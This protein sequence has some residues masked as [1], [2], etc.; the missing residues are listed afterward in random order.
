MTMTS[1][2]RVGLVALGL[3]IASALLLKMHN[4]A[5]A[6]SF[7][8]PA[9]PWWALPRVWIS[10]SVLVPAVVP[11][12]I[13]IP[14]SVTCAALAMVVAL[15]ISV[16]SNW[17]GMVPHMKLVPTRTVVWVFVVDILEFMGATVILASAATWGM[18]LW[19]SNISLQADR[20]R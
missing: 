1:P 16:W 19:S 17:A 4:E 11:A 7:E 15:A 14:R 13:R 18:K 2:A 3:G 20:E 12:I 6:L 10:L 8:N 5:L 9:P